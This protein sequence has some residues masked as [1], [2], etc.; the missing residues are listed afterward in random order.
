[1]KILASLRLYL[2]CHCKGC[3][4]TDWL[5][6]CECEFIAACERIYT[7]HGRWRTKG[8]GACAERTTFDFSETPARPNHTHMYAYYNTRICM[9]MTQVSN[10]TCMCVRVCEQQDAGWNIAMTSNNSVIL[11]AERWTLFYSFL[12]CM[13]VNKLRKSTGF[14][15]IALLTFKIN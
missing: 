14:N 11:H 2:E 1:M 6:S 3:V 12:I 15:L 9:H 8:P 7:R 13:W 4:C 10:H 5:Y